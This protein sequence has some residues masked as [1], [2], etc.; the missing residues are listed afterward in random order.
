VSSLKDHQKIFILI[1]GKAPGRTRTGAEAN[2]VAEEV[3]RMEGLDVSILR[4]E[5][6]TRQAFVLAPTVG[7]TVITYE[8]EGKAALEIRQLAQEIAECLQSTAAA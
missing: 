7:Q 3:F 6:T 5:V 8:P 1:N 4:T 2:A